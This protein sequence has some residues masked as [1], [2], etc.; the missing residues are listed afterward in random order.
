MSNTLI[1][2]FIL[3]AMMVAAPAA[4]QP[5]SGKFRERI[6]QHMDRNQD[7]NVS[8]TEYND[9][10]QRRFERMDQNGD[11]SITVQEMD[12]HMERVRAMR[13]QGQGPLGSSQEE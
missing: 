2:L 12:H 7:C 4:A 11:G 6:F 8:R 1:I 9:A 13:Q 10:M 3:V 5:G